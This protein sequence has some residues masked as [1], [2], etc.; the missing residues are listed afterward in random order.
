MV[1]DVVSGQKLA[2]IA[3]YS[4]THLLTGS[5]IGQAKVLP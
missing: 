1:C 2:D 3:K 5:E 4:G